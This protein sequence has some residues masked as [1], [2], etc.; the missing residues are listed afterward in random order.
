MEKKLLVAIDFK[1]ESINALK[2]A[3]NLAKQVNAKVYCLYVVEETG[4]I[5]SLFITEETAAK[6]KDEA[7]NRLKE[8]VYPVFEGTGVECEVVVRKGKAFT[9]IVKTAKD[10]SVNFIVMG[11]KNRIDFTKN[12][13]GSNTNHII[14]ASRIPVITINNN[15]SYL[16][17]SHVLLPLDLSQPIA[18]K[19]GNAIYL[20]KLL[21]AKITVMSVISDE[22]AFL[23]TKYKRRM[24]LIKTEFKKHEISCN[25]HLVESSAKPDVEINNYTKEVD[26]DIIMIM[27][28][29]ELDLYDFF[30][31]STAQNI[32]TNARIPVISTIPSSELDLG[33][34]VSTLK[35]FFDPLNIFRARS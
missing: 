14:S 9:E 18:A 19:V 28:Q 7:T 29:K 20:A 32:I 15:N 35:Q 24:E 31:G 33:G 11:R 16:F 10:F 17:G 34:G 1:E 22:F 5:T 30:I 6:I 12:V 3:I 27:T 26:A 21:G 25:T 2:Y 23:K 4:F 13:I 8:L